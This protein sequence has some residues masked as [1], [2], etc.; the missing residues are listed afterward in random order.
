MKPGERR[1][2]KHG[3]TPA[4]VLMFVVFTGAAYA[5]DCPGSR[6]MW[7]DWGS[8]NMIFGPFMMV[9]FMI[10]IIVVFVLLFRRVEGGSTRAPA[11]FSVGNTA[12]DILKE[13]FA[14][15]EIDKEEFEERKHLLSD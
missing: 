1:L 5:Q 2:T 8:G 11:P 9:L 3:I 14:R 4:F 13:R 7:G 15:G 10:G 6:H 12:L